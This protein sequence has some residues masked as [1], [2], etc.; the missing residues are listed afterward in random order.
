MPTS[1]VQTFSIELYRLDP[2]YNADDARELPVNLVASTTFAKGQV[3]AESRTVPGTY[4]KYT[5][6]ARVAAGAAPTLTHPNT[7]ALAAGVYT[8][9]Y[10]YKFADGN[11]S[12]ASP[13]ASVTA[14]ANDVVHAAAIT[15]LPAGV[16]SVDWYMSEG[17]GDTQLAFAA[18]NDGSALDIPLPANGAPELETA[19]TFTEYATGPARMILRYACVTDSAGLASIG[20]GSSQ[21]PG[22]DKQVGVDAF[23]EGVFRTEDLTGLTAKALSDMG[24]SVINGT[25]AG[26][27]TI[28]I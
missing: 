3:L 27:G 19:A 13:A 21:I 11:V 15:P 23:Y 20:D 8:V 5:E 12:A 2:A 1:P 25:I 4:E 6:T 14:I 28:E 16:A 9:R 17:P 22:G 10:R 24:G 26:T 18:N 7:G